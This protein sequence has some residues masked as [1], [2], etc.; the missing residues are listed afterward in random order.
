MGEASYTFRTVSR[1]AFTRSESFAAMSIVWKSSATFACVCVSSNRA[2]TA[3][4]STL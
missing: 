2:M 3:A 1:I 4:S